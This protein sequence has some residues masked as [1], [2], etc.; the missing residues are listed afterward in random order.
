MSKK[1]KDAPHPGRDKAKSTIANATGAGDN[2]QNGEVHSIALDGM[3]ENWFLEYA[4][5]VILER[6]VP[7]IEDGLS[8]CSAASCTLS[9]RWMTAGLTR[10]PM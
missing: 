3:Y 9:R 10:S 5:Y 2:G 8:P 1:K 6:A 7:R 4:S